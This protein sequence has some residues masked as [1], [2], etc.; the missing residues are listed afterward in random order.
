MGKEAAFGHFFRLKY[1]KTLLNN[2]GI[3]S[4]DFSL[5]TDDGRFVL[6][7]A[8][9][10]VARFPHEATTVP[11]ALKCLPT[12]E[13]TTFLVVEL[14]TGVVRDRRVFKND[15][16]SLAH[17]CGVHLYRNTLAV[18]SIQYQRV[19]LFQ[20]KENG[21]LCEFQQI[22]NLCHQDDELFL[23]HHQRLIEAFEERQAR[24]MDATASTVLPSS[25]SPPPSSS[26]VPAASLVPLHLVTAAQLVAQQQQHAGVVPPSPLSFQ[27]ELPQA[28]SVVPMFQGFPYLGETEPEEPEG[29][30]PL[31]TL[32]QKV[33]AFLF[34]QAREK[35]LGNLAAK[36]ID[37]TRPLRWF[38]L[39]FAYLE[40]LALWKLQFL[41]DNI[42][43]LRFCN[44]EV[45]AGRVD[46]RHFTL[47]FC[48]CAEGVFLLGSREL[49]QSHRLLCHLQLC[50][51]EGGVN[52]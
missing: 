11:G 5:F 27:F 2:E 49:R 40:T 30:A 29:Q 4:K 6:V 36:K 31:P 19:H 39:N 15:S 16:I 44:P 43:L 41:D 42:L 17:Q 38:Y 20:I 51:A 25:A 37:P 9:A 10:A 21:A 12:L 22:G 13:T 28:P 18:T 35:Y 50:G 52:L 48:F 3:L 24:V 7:A 1:E 23:A 14:A 34:L 46:K 26:L 33:L 45:V 32:K 47:L 8:V